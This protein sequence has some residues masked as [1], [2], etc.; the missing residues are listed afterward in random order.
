GEKRFP[1]PNLIVPISAPR[2]EKADAK[3]Q[4]VGPINNEVHMVPV[5]VAGAVLHIWSRRVE[6]NQGAM[7]ISVRYGVAVKLGQADGLNDR[8]PLGR[9]FTQIAICFLSIKPVEEFP[10][11]VAEPKKRLTLLGHEES[12]V[13]TYLESW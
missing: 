9:T 3:A 13:L 5:I 6:V 1:I 7:A 10:G 11:G 4:L 8:E 12:F 2:R